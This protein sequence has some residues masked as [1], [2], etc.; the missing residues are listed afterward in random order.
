[1]I[2]GVHRL[3][4]AA[5]AG[6]DLVGAAGDHLIGV[7]VRLGARPGLP[8]DQRELAVEIAARDFAGGL[9]DHFGKLGVEPADPGIHPRRRLLDEAERTDDLER[10]LLLGPERK[11]LNR[12]LGLRAPICVG[13]D[14]DRA[15]AV[16]FGAGVGHGLQSVMLNS[17]QHPF[18]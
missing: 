3:L 10:H 9:L 6:E 16:G 17:V 13:R 18:R 1:M 2:V 11:I 7:H 14:V 12:A 15:E 4:P 5:L 8:D